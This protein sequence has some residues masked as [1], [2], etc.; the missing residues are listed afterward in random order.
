MYFLTHLRVF[1]SSVGIVAPPEK[2]MHLKTVTRAFPRHCTI[3]RLGYTSSI[4]S[5]NATPLDNKIAAF[6][7]KRSPLLRRCKPQHD[8]DVWYTL[9]PRYQQARTSHT[10]Q[11][12]R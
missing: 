5:E 11:T 8:H 10:A 7:G 2:N 4:V 3:R 6:G 9:R 12:D 1:P